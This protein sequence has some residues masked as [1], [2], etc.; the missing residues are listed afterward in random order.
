MAATRNIEQPVITRTSL[1][2][3]DKAINEG[4]L[5]QLAFYHLLKF[6]FNNSC[7]YNYRSRMD[8]LAKMFDICPKTLYSYFKVLRS[9]NLIFDH[10]NNLVLTSIGKFCIDRKCSILIQEDYSLS[11]I[12]ALLYGKLIE[13][14]AG[15]LS[16][17]E[18]IKK[19]KGADVEKSNNCEKRPLSSL[20]KMSN[21]LIANVLKVSEFKSFKVIK[22]LEMLKVIIVHKQPPILIKNNFTDLVS[23][24]DFPGY[25]FNIGTRLYSRAASEI[26]FLQFPVVIK[27]LTLKLY[28]RLKKRDL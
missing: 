4:W 17:G 14:K 8:E 27:P 7:L 26:E 6:R 1:K 24:E 21:R 9:K 13:R 22:C 20:V 12:V 16:F 5:K 25:R 10:S 15:K 2:L 3:I 11:D 18:L 19:M 28:K 23:V